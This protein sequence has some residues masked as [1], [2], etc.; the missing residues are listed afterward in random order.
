MATGKADDENG[1][2]TH[3]ALL[4]RFATAVLSNAEDLD[5]ARE[6]L[7]DAIGESAT[8][9]AASIVACFDGLNRVADATG[10]RLDPESEARGASKIVEIL[11]F[12][13]LGAAR[14]QAPATRRDRAS[15]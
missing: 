2:V 11:E 15:P 12:E 4:R 3:G 6:R 5:E 10:I 13:A 9:Q 1:G 14:S 8:A 7:I